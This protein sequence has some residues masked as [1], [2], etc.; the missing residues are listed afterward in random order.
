MLC[1][2]Q[3]AHAEDCPLDPLPPIPV[4]FIR[5]RPAVP[6]RINGTAVFFMLDTGFTRT[7]VTPVARERFQL[8]PDPRYQNRI[9]GTGGESVVSQAVIKSF[10]FSGLAFA[11]TSIPVIGLDRS[12]NKGLPDLFS[13]V[14]GGDFLRSYDVEFDFPHGQMR[15]WRRPLCEPVRPAWTSQYTALPVQIATGNAVVLPVR[16]NG[17]PLRA[18]FDTGAALI[19]LTLGAVP[20]AGIDPASLQADPVIFTSGAGGLGSKG[21][22]HQL[23]SLEIAGEY[24]KGP[25]VGI[26]KFDLANADLLL[27]EPWIRAHRI[28]LSYGAGVMFVEILQAK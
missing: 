7:S 9:S 3:S 2:A 16:V 15:L 13:G 24:L 23:Q 11:D 21:W 28:W 25:H 10:E 6:V 18:M 17:Q 5:D 8:P 20:H 22:T 27:G 19:L 14:I 26:Q 1:L 4:T 12:D